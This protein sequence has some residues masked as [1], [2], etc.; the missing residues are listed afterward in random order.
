M[1]VE[2]ALLQTTFIKNTARFEFTIKPVAAY[3]MIGSG[4][5]STIL[6]VILFGRASFF[7]HGY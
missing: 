3:S 1:A 2:N 7:V 4:I 5:P 6:A